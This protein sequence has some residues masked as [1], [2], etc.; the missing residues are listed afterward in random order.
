MI[1]PVLKLILP[2]RHCRK[3]KCRL[4]VGGGVKKVTA[5]VTL[6]LRQ[7]TTVS[8]LLHESVEGDCIYWLVRVCFGISMS[9]F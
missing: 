9:N 4:G 6:K 2:M 1:T 3:R 8:W 5:E 7:S